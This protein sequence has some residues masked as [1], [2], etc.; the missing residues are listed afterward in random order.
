MNYEFGE[1]FVE[2]WGHLHFI[3]SLLYIC[4]VCT[5]NSLTSFVVGLYSGYIVF[6]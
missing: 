5:F 4:T 6:H 3:L 1:N 2:R